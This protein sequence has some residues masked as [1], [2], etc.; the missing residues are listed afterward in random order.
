MPGV[1]LEM[2]RRRF[3]VSDA[4]LRLVKSNFSPEVYADIRQTAM[5]GEMS[6]E[7]IK[8]LY[9]IVN[10]PGVEMESYL[11]SQ[12]VQMDEMH[13]RSARILALAMRADKANVVHHHIIAS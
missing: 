7:T 11:T 2:E 3:I 9:E 10:N 13:E 1:D 5:K 12:Y 4:V 8:M 6:A